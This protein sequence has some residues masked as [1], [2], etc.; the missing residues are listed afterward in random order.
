MEY[1]TLVPRLLPWKGALAK[2]RQHG[3]WQVGVI[4]RAEII[5]LG[6][7]ALMFVI[8]LLKMGPLSAYTWVP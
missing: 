4:W 1:T 7:F 5:T 8:A 3:T 2:E 6:L